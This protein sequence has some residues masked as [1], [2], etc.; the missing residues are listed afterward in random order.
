MPLRILTAN[1]YTGRA[2]PSSLAAVLDEVRPDVVAVQELSPNAAGVLEDWGSVRLLDPSLDTVGMGLAVATKAT[3]DRLEFPHRN[4]IR[5]SFDGSPWGLDVV[6]VVNAHLVNP[7]ARPLRWARRARSQELAALEEV[8]SQP[9]TTRVLVGDL[10]SSPAWPLYRRLTELATDGAVAAGTARRTWGYFPRSPR[11]LRIDH[12]FVQ[13][14]S[15]VRT[16]LV[17]IRGADHSALVVD[18]EPLASGG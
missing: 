5:A 4:P 8:L 7:V 18:V 12:A 11:L 2:D 10:N 1:L 6:E 3:L 17:K 15:C 9:A 13:G 14:A 16:G